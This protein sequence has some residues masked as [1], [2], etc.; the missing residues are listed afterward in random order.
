MLHCHVLCATPCIVDAFV[1]KP[2]FLL[3]VEPIERV[4]RD[5]LPFLVVD[6]KFAVVLVY[7]GVNSAYQTAHGCSITS[8]K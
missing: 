3:P 2:P 6:E 1:L 4:C 7:D 5:D 8:T